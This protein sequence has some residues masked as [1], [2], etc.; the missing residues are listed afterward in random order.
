MKFNFKVSKEKHPSDMAFKSLSGLMS[1]SKVPGWFK[2]SYVF[3][4]LYSVIGNGILIRDLV[5]AIL[6]NSTP[7][8]IVFIAAVLAV[9]VGVSIGYFCSWSNIVLEK[10][11]GKE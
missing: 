7:S 6:N 5:V 3:M 1:N 11:I 8:S 2:A 9:S 10:Y 4:L